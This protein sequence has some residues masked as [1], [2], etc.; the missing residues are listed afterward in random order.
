MSAKYSKTSL[1]SK[2]PALY[3]AQARIRTK[4]SVAPARKAVEQDTRRRER[5]QRDERI[6]IPTSTP[7]RSA[8]PVLQVRSV[9]RRRGGRAWRRRPTQPRPRTISRHSRQS[10]GYAVKRRGD[11]SM[12]LLRS[13]IASD[14][15]LRL[16]RVYNN[17]HLISVR[18]GRTWGDPNVTMSPS[19]LNS[20]SSS[21]APAS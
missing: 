15:T 21:P 20:W 19:L 18:S 16:P 11:S 10:L 4:V 14:I 9:A 7:L 3:D 8:P 1:H 6:G 5:R 2:W 12:H 17:V 13:G